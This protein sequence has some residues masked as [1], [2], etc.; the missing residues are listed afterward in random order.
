MNKKFLTIITIL[1]SFIYIPKIYG[2]QVFIKDITGKNITLEVES[3]DTIEAVKSKIED[4]EGILAIQQRLIFAGKE[5]QDGRTLADYNVQKESTIHLLLKLIF[6]EVKVEVKGAKVEIE[7]KKVEKFNVKIGSSID[8]NVVVDEGYMINN[9]SVTNGTITKNE[10]IYTLSNVT[11]ENIIMTIETI[12]VGIK[13]IEKT[14]TSDNI[15]EYTIT[16][17]DDSKY[18][19]NIKNG[20][21]GVDGVNGKDGINGSNGKDGVNGKDGITP[22][23]R[24]NETTNEW[25]VSYDNKITWESLGVVAIGQD[26]SDGKDGQNATIKYGPKEYTIIVV[27]GL[28]SLVGNIGWIVSLKKKNMTN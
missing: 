4:K 7:G 3:S 12:P 11:T 23:L 24:I 15:D 20:K 9:I 5:L 13:K 10:D 18:T 2:M 6:S 19:F 21:D 17:S 28:L 25:E 22:H 14:N 8:F 27:L 16:L 1:I 26:G